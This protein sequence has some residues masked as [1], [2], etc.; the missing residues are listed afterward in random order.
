MLLR[1]GFGAKRAW[2]ATQGNCPII[3]GLR[4]GDD[5]SVKASG[6]PYS[7]GGDGPRPKFCLR[8]AITEMRGMRMQSFSAAVVEVVKVVTPDKNPLDFH[9]VPQ[10]EIDSLLSGQ[11]F[12]DFVD[13]G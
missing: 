7:P 8:T 13:T 10:V 1:K 5:G 11:R 9:L 3:D 12:T 2:N 4:I 6:C